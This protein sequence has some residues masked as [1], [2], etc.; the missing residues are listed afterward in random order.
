VKALKFAGNL[1]GRLIILAL[2]GDILYLYYAGSWYD[3]IKAIEIIEVVLIY[4]L[5]VGS[6]VWAIFYIRGRA[7]S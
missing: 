1:L 5:A 6:I 2:A 7:K 3:P 4:C